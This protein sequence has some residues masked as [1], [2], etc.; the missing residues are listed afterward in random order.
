MDF[1]LRFIQQK[2]FLLR[3][4]FEYAECI[5]YALCMWLIEKLPSHSHLTVDQSAYFSFHLCLQYNWRK[6]L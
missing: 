5:L 3:Y 6:R 1:A 2:R 4:F